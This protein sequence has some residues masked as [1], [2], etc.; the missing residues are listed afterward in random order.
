M[1]NTLKNVLIVVLLAVIAGLVIYLIPKRE[2]PVDERNAHVSDFLTCSEAGFPVM[3]SYPAQCRTSDG[4]VFVED[5]NEN[6]EVVV[7][8]PTQGQTVTSPMTVTGKAKGNWFFEANLPVT[9]KDQ[10]G[11]V[12]AQKG[13]QAQGDWM[14]TDYVNFT[15]V[16]EFTTPETQ[17]GVLLIQKDNPS[18][19]TEN[20]A[21][22]AIPVRFR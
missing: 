15:T 22:Y 12:L 2:D 10:N 11:K 21:S 4:R 6:A 19:L 8:V 1:N 7:T 3:E 18:G 5:V 20:D 9:L 14:T 17:Y 13:A 16:L